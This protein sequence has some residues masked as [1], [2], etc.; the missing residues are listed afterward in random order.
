VKR[1]FAFAP[2]FFILAACATLQPNNEALESTSS[3]TITVAKSGAAYTS[4][5]AAATVAKPGDIVCVRAGTYKEYVNFTRSGTATQRITYL[6]Y[7]GEKVVFD[8]SGP[9]RR[10]YGPG[11]FEVDKAS[12]LTFRGFELTQGATDGFLIYESTH[13]RLYNIIVS[14]NHVSGINFY[15][16]TPQKNTYHLVQDSIAHHN[17]G[18]GGNS[19]GIKTYSDSRITFRHNIAYA[20]SDDGFDTWL[21]RN[22]ILEFNI[23]YGN[24]WGPNGN[25]NGGGFKL[26]GL[27]NGPNN[28]TLQGGY[29]TV[30]FNASF[31]NR[32]EGFNTNNG[33]RD[34]LYNNT[35]CG[36]PL[37]FRS[38]GTTGKE[39]NTFKNNLS[40]TNDNVFANTDIRQANSWD[41]GLNTNT[42][43]SKDPSSSNFLRLPTT[44]PVLDKGVNINLSYAGPA[45]DLGA[46]EVGLPWP[47]NARP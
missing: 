29:N 39:F 41:L 35:A 44:S 21:G 47:R 2:V 17:N 4:L 9:A 15:S 14:Y 13:V 26:G 12:Y 1:L 36:N 16:D 32:S 31:G 23:S 18:T 20:N 34:Y 27:S 3:C 38:F 24:G 46:F 5:Q 37:N 11:L 42:F 10:E 43:L 6:A 7:P 45:P 8:G 30:R 25:G 22:N 28:Q 33:T 19:D 40:C